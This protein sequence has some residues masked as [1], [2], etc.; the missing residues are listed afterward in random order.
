M[1]ARE[2]VIDFGKYPASNEVK[3][4][5]RNT[6]YY[7]DNEHGGERVY[8]TFDMHPSECPGYK[9]LT[10]KP[11]RFG[12]KIVGISYGAG[13]LGEFQNSLEFCETVAVYYW[14]GDMTYRTPLIVQLTSGYSSV[15]FVASEGGEADWTILFSSQISVNLLIWLDSENCRWNGAH[16]IDISK[17]YEESYNCYSCHRQVLGVTTLSGQ[18]G[19]RKVVHRLTGGCVGR[20][21]NGAKHVTDIMV[22]EGTPTVEVYWYPS[23]L[24]LP[25]VVYLPVPLTEY[26][27]E[28][29]SESSIWYRKLP[30]NRWTRMENYSPAINEPESFVQLLKKIYE[31]TT[32]SHLRFYYEDTGNKP[33]K[34]APSR[35]IIIGIALLNLVGLTF[36]CFLFRKFSPQIRRFI[37]KGYTLL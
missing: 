35:E 31:E 19:Y 13:P 21:K 26:Y 14:S 11:Q 18:K 7:D 29:T 25:V 24:G 10:Y 28:E 12:T 2:V 16:I 9:K 36:I 17:I 8:I 3:P 1:N 33:V 22:S 37:L 27:E 4:G 23:R 32:P 15:Y 34:T 6:Y 30:G 20:I 5:H